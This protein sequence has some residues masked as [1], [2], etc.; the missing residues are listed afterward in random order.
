MGEAKPSTLLLISVFMIDVIAVWLAVA[1]EINRN[2]AKV[3]SDEE[4]VYVYCAYES[5]IA[6][7]YGVGSFLFLLVSQLLIM[8][9]TRC[10]C[11]L[12]LS[13]L[14]PGGT[15]TWAIAL[16]IA[17]WLTF[18]IA[19]ACLI[20]GAAKNAY[21]TKYRDSVNV[22]DLECKTLRKGVFAAGAA[23]TVYN[24]IVSEV[25]CMTFAKAKEEERS[26]FLVSLI[27]D[28]LEPA[29]TPMGRS[30]V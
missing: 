18:I 19:E 15:R 10:L 2:T 4:S 12:K 7:V 9:V 17:S 5:D 21:H 29:P 28:S 27:T 16:F 1:A 11:T 23:F 13:S 6:S 30:N 3:V 20:G 22:T 24:V 26:S 25:Y 14:K 8:G